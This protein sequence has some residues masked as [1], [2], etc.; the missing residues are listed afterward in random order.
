MDDAAARQRATIP[1]IFDDVASRFI[2]SCMRAKG[3]DHQFD[4]KEDAAFETMRRGCELGVNFA[5]YPEC[6]VNR[7]APMVD[8]EMKRQ[9]QAADDALRLADQ[10]VRRGL[11]ATRIMPVHSGLITSPIVSC[12]ASM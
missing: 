3:Y 12:S 9:T 11:A 4:M 8:L 7:L 1:K 6:H 5:T 10:D 2:I